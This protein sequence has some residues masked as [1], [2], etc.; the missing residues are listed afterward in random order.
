M[1]APH[2]TR[3]WLLVAA[4]AAVFGV[5]GDVPSPG[6]GAATQEVRVVEVLHHDPR[7]YTQGLEVRG[8]RL[9]ESTGRF[10]RSTVAVG[11]PGK[12]PAIRLRLPAEFFGEGL[13]VVGR[14]LWQLT[15]R[16][17]VAVER[18]ARTLR[19]IRRVP[20]P[21][22]GWGICYQASRQRVVTSDG[23]AW[24]TYR[25]A[26]TLA[27]VGRV[28]VTEPGGDARPVRYL[29]E[30]E[31]VGESVY[32][33][34]FGSDRIVRVDADSGRVTAD[35]D[36]SGLWGRGERAGVLN[37]IAAVPGSDEFLLTGKNWPKTF[38]VRFEARDE[39]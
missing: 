16:N 38:R 1:G 18:D 3:T 26:G 8:G 32:A 25:D 27:A 30:L 13:T 12:P 36:A 11:A 19:E 31:C 6:P 28:R 7:A 23:S 2:P 14:R 22:E 5:A 29:N 34:V 35:I 33:N 17:G 9:Y 10:G 20:Y 15:W 21:D 4:L 24:L 37:G 39:G